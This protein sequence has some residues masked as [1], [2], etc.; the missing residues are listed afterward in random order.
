MRTSDGFKLIAW[1]VL[2]FFAAIILTVCIL[3]VGGHLYAAIKPVAWSWVATATFLSAV[4]SAGIVLLN[5]LWHL[6]QAFHAIGLID[7]REW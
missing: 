7:L 2:L 5:G 4:L 6:G 1:K 3:V